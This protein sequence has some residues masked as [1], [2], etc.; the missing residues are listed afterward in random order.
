MNEQTCIEAH[1]QTD[2]QTDRQR[3]GQPESRRIQ[4]ANSRASYSVS[5]RRQPAMQPA[6]RPGSKPVSHATASQAAG[7]SHVERASEP[8]SQ[9]VSQPDSR[10]AANQHQ[11]APV[12][13]PGSPRQPARASSQSASQPANRVVLLDVALLYK[14]PV[15]TRL[16]VYRRSQHQVDGLPPA[17]VR[18][19]SEQT[20]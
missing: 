13:Q 15:E 8:G 1:K 10:P 19:I 7:A 12:R 11:P 16:T 14:S 3:H 5:V 18:V 2:T 17:P 4:P 9:P 20:F 6:T